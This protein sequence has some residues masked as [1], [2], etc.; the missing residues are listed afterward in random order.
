MNR[1]ENKESCIEHL[2][3]ASKRVFTFDSNDELENHFPASEVA[4]AAT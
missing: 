1:H 3:S 4:C 2:C